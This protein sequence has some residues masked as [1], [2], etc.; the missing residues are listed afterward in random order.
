M[1]E[2]LQYY[3]KNA[4]AYFAQTRDVQMTP[5]RERFLFHVADQGKILD[6]GCGSGRDALAFLQAGYRVDAFDASPAMAHLASKHLGLG[7]GV[8]RFEDMDMDHEYDGIWACASLLHVSPDELPGV[9]KRLHQAL[10]TGGILYASFK[11]G[12]GRQ[13]WQ[14][15]Q[16]TNMNESDFS[17]LLGKTGGFGI[18]DSWTSEDRR[19]D[20]AGE[21][22]FNALLRAEE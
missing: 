18:V 11:Q 5:L 20:R 22:W 19:A 12:A 15:R 10:K 3:Q 21:T 17:V 16:F 13:V 14:G 8:L 4:Q 9:F 6:A 1:N 7:V 2:T